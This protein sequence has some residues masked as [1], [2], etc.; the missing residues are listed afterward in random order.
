MSD[1]A[2]SSEELRTLILEDPKVVLNDR[3]VMRALVSADNDRMGDN[4]V[5]LKTVVLQKLE[6]RLNKMEEHQQS[7][8]S[9]AYDNVASTTSIHKS[10]LDLLDPTT[11]TAFLKYLE[12]DLA[13]S[14]NVDIAKLCLEAPTVSED[15][16]ATLQAEFGSGVVFL[17][18]GEIDYYITLGRETKP[19]PIT[20]RPVKRGIEKVHGEQ[21]SDIRSEALLKIDLGAGNRQGLLVLA[22]FDEKQYAPKMGTDLLVFYGSV[23]EKVVKGWLAHE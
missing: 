19:R 21:F 10:V 4:I 2:K 20:L 5:D 11:F 14:L 18:A 1:E 12:E 6:T 17:Q 3:D 8:L 15:D 23:F 13:T 16:L 7:L 9:A 22:S